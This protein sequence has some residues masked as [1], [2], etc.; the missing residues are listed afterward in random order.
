MKVGVFFHRVFKESWPV[1]GD[2]FRRFPEVMQEALASPKVELIEPK[3][4]SEALLRKVHSESLLESVKRMYV[5]DAARLAVGGCVQ[6]AEMCWRGH[7]ARALVFT[8]AAGH[9]A[10]VSYAWGGTYL[11]CTGPAIANLREKF[12][13]V[14]AAILDTDSHHG[15]GCREIFTGDR[16]VLHVCF[17]SS[18][19]VEDAG[20]KI[21][22][23]VGW[24]TTDQEYLTL[25]EDCFIRAA[26]EFKPDIIL[27]FH[28]H[29][30]C[31]GDY[32][33][34]GLT[35]NLQVELVKLVRDL[36]D[37]VCDGRYVVLT[38]GGARADIAE[39]IY[40]RAIEVLS[41]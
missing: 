41:A 36:A 35:P 11:S 32:G 37:E 25:V 28:G 23:D 5:W 31:I 33:D 20:T 8:V 24:K 10:G 39:L 7:L 2:K 27:H 12:G 29:D 13:R 22:V 40:P 18:S 38:G 1:I 4:V 6:A 30:T 34:R 26:R 14:R 3:P 17:C 16:D 21:C 15:D 9:H 19:R